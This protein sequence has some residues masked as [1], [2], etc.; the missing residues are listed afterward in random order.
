[1]LPYLQ[2]FWILKWSRDGEIIHDHFHCRESTKAHRLGWPLQIVHIPVFGCTMPGN[3]DIK[4]NFEANFFWL[5]RSLLLLSSDLYSDCIFVLK[6]FFKFYT[7]IACGLKNFNRMCFN[8]GLGNRRAYYR[9]RQMQKHADVG[10]RHQILDRLAPFGLAMEDAAFQTGLQG[11][12]LP[13]SFAALGEEPGK[14]SRGSFFPKEVERLEHDSGSTTIYRG[15]P[16]EKV[17]LPRFVKRELHDQ[18]RCKPC[19]YYRKQ[20]C[21]YGDECRFCHFCTAEQIRKWQ[22]RQHYDQRAQ[23][24][25]KLQEEGPM[26]WDSSMTQG[27]DLR[28]TSWVPHF[29]VLSATFGCRTGR[30][31]SSILSVNPCLTG[32]ECHVVPSYLDSYLQKRSVTYTSFW[33]IHIAMCPNLGRK[34]H[35]IA[36]YDFLGVWDTPTNTKADTARLHWEPQQERVWGKDNHHDKRFCSPLPSTFNWL[37]NQLCWPVFRRQF[38]W[39]LRLLCLFKCLLFTSWVAWGEG[40]RMLLHLL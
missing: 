18:R 4:F 2:R 39:K 22:S 35:N 6:V 36:M 20:G 10:Q 19:L 17:P 7:S 13:P 37:A 5:T 24:R 32:V 25:E 31:R 28:V 14:G 33:S 8:T 38:L 15:P 27:Q 1:M 40:W 30:K 16:A 12:H 11:L 29:V 21:W 23:Q 3:V 26:G 9:S 34:S